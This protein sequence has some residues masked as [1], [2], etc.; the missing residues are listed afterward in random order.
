[1]SDKHKETVRKVEEAWDKD[2]LDD[3]DQHFHAKFHN[4]SRVPMLPFG[5]EGSK[6]AHKMAK[7]SFPDRK[8]EILD[9]L[10]ED[11]RVM[12]RA[13]ITGTNKGGVPWVGAEANDAPIDIESWSVYRLEDGK[14]VEHWGINDAYLLAIQTGAVKPAMPAPA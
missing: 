11:D 8:V 3:L 6:Q 12:V 4:H 10:A 14:I 13:R 2:R 5:L 1:M 9:I 7:G